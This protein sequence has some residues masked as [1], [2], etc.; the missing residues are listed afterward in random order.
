MRDSSV[1]DTRRVRVKICGVTS[2]NASAA[3]ASAGADAI[4][5]VFYPAS[6]RHLADLELAREIAFA[7]GPLINVVGLFVNPRPQEVDNVLEQVPLT[8]LQFHGDETEAF[9]SRFGRPY[10]KALRMKQGVDV[11]AQASLYRSA[12]GV[13]LD[14]YHPSMPG[15]TGEVFDWQRIPQFLPRPL[16]LAGGLRSENIARAVE[17]V[18]PWAVDVSGGVE[19]SPGVKDPELIREFIER[20]RAV[21]ISNNQ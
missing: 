17:T 20:A 14:A 12:S 11:A 9:C 4:G 10:L 15:G 1:I 2:A 13:L 8:L 21:E 3:A 6:P 16:I 5:L 18:R 19:S 7:A